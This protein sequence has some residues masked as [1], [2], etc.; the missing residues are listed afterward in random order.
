MV[1]S[2]IPF[3]FYFLPLVLLIYFLVRDKY[4]NTV[5]FLS[6]LIFYGWGEPRTLFIMLFSILSGFILAISVEKHRGSKKS[7]HYLILAILMSLAPLLYFKY[8]NFILDNV[9]QLTNLPIPILKVALPV[10][11]SFYTFQILSYV[12]DVYR[13]DTN[14]QKN[15]IKLGTYITMFPQLVAGP[16][17]RYT[18]IKGSLDKRLHSFENTSL[19]LR[20][21]ILG[22]AKK[23]LIANRLGILVDLCRT[24][25]SP[26]V[27]GLWV[28]AISFTLQIYFDFSSYSDMAIGLGRVFGFHF[29]ENFNY[30]LISRSL[31]EF[32]RRWHISLGSWF[33]DYVYIPLGGNRVSNLKWFRNLLIVW[34]LTGLWHGADWHFILW[35]AYFILFLVIEKH[36]IGQFLKQHRIVSHLYTLFFIVIS[37]V[38][39]NANDIKD[40]VSTIGSLFGQSKIPIYN[41]EILYHLSSYRLSLVLALFAATPL[42][43]EV[44]KRLYKQQSSEKLMSILEIIS[45]S[46]LFLMVTAYLV[47]GSFNPFLYFRF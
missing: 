16:I 14:A 17:V 23:V 15:F 10:G 26:S 28:Y 31:T 20:R 45:L 35:G 6:S 2:S 12:V 42:I 40:A 44:A 19:G 21:F 22:L 41:H 3:I 36:F 47:D 30:P 37:M 39:F 24:T 8:S 46:I 18:D 34:L 43:K 4:K 32:W 33:R 13:G 38:I 7:L 11:I 5:L 29:L 25:S 1:F 27:L 9:R